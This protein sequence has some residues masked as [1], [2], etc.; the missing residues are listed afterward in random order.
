MGETPPGP[1]RYPWAAWGDLSAFFGL[2]LDNLTNL[3]LLWV[4]LAQ[5]GFPA[6]VFFSRM[7]PGT[8]L[9]VLIGDL[10][11]T[12]MAFRLARRT[13]NPRVTAMPLGLDTPSTIGV[14][15]AVLLPVFR[16]AQEGGMDVP[17]AAD[18]SWKVGMATMVFMGLL[19][20]AA[21]FVGPAIQRV[22]P[23]A[24]LLGSL[25]GVGVTLLGFIPLLHMFALPAV[26]LTALGL[27]LFTLVARFDLPWRLPGAFAAVAAGTLVYYV[28]GPAGL[29]GGPFVLPSPTFAVTPPL[30][31][32]GW[33][34]EARAALAYLPF[35]IPFGL[36]TIVGGINVT[37]SARCAG[38]D[39]DTRGILLTEA[40]A[41]LVAGLF[42]GVVQSTPYIGHPAYK[43]MGARAA[44]TLATG[45][46]VGLGG[47]LG[48]VSWIVDAIPAAAVAPLL[49]FVGLEITGQAYAVV[50]R[51]HYAAVFL[52]LLPVVGELVRIALATVL[53]D[54]G[55]GGR[56]PV[57]PEA[58]SWL[59]VSALLG[60]GFILTSMLWAAAVARLVDRATG[61][62]ALFFLA[63]ATLSFFGF[64]HSVLPHG[65][66]YLPWTLP[67]PEVPY[68]L[69]LIYAFLALL[70][71][72]LPRV[73]PRSAT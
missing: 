69:A 61:Q 32:L 12:W 63:L 43:A 34:E 55:L 62:A 30:P 29:L 27:L 14:A 70:V 2:M 3:V 49:L 52:A 48:W 40:G 42:G 39:F 24:G 47:A 26:G 25:A 17:A 11:Y 66:V 5:A 37:E 64:V 31:T 73:E 41:T 46:F 53:F 67:D 58:L 51:R 22:V 7:V 28:L 8:A 15:L 65:D 21:A 20:T 4:L 59:Q 35:A 54:P 50:P 60:H 56:M 16:A 19:K 44:Y 23:Q 9:G 45:L 6:D 10:V 57:S 68:R 18:V 13:G 33:L 71:W 38:D 1:F 72:L 36:L